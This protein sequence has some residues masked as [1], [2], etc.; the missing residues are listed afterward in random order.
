M[1]KYQIENYIRYTKDLKEC[2]P[3][4]KDWNEYTRNELIVKFMPLVE[5]L[6]RKFSTTQQ[7]SGVLSINDLI[8]CGNIGLVVAVDKINWDTIGESSNQE[9]TLKS[10]LAKRIKGAIRRSIDQARGDIRIPE[11][12]LQEIRNDNFQDP[13]LAS[14]F[15]NA[16]SLSYDDDWNKDDRHAI[17]RHEIED[18]SEPYNIDLMNHYAFAMMEKH[19]EP[20]EREIIRLSYGLDCE[21]H[22]AKAIAEILNIN[23]VSAV[24]RISEIKTAAIR[25]L[26]DNTNGSQLPVF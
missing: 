8:Q 18:S 15:N 5:N 4:G 17:N 21:K 13:V 12:K 10:F 26:I 2:M 23:G 25:K 11:H 14:L 22:S 7:A 9:Q 3:E 20:Q 6:A 16:I 19:L 24:V 1:K